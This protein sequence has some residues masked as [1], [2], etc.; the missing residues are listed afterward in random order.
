[1]GLTMNTALQED[2]WGG[3]PEAIQ[4]HYDAGNNFYQKWLD[5]TMS[6]SSALWDEQT[7]KN[8]LQRA[9]I[10][11]HLWHINSAGVQNG[12]RLLDIG[13][14][15]GSQIQTF[16]HAA[17]DNPKSAV[18]LT[19]AK[20]QKKYAESR[21][22]SGAEF[23]LESWADHQP[24]QMYD[25]IISVG[26]IEHFAK[27]QSTHAEKMDVYRTLFE[28]CRSWLDKGGCFSLQ[29]VTYGTLK[30]ED[31]NLFIA[32]EIFPES[33]LPHTYELF[34]AAEGLFEVTAYRNDRYDYARTCDLWL[35]NLQKNRDLILSTE[36]EVMYKRYENY[37]KLS[38]AG[39]LQ[40][41]M[42]L[43]RLQM[44]AI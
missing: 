2:V 20:E 3:S 14:G 9:Q 22:L 42:L 15:W 11:K 37:L 40:G 31:Q 10:N 36:G 21:E 38:V 23:R 7:D 18:G 12:G 29:S 30:P 35:K 8:D 13:C 28:R 32:H 41:K 17:G 43:V 39:F 24:E 44:R 27:F 33:E 5:P 4:H 26:A 34:Q 19:L 25:G 1:M 6:Y 16:Y